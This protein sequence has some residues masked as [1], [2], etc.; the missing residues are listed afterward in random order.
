MDREA[1]RA[2][3]HG[4]TKSWTWL[5]DWAEH[6]CIASICP[7][8]N[9]VSLVPFLLLNDSHLD[10]WA[11][12]YHSPDEQY[13]EYFQL[14]AFT[15]LQ[16][17]FVYKFLCEHS[18]Q[19][20][21]LL[22]CVQLFATLGLQHTKLPCSSTT[23]G[24]CLNMAIESVMP[25]N[26]LMLCHPLLLLPSIFPSIRVFSSESVL[27]IRRPKYCSFSFSISPSSEYSG[28]ISFRMD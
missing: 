16:W 18:V 17:I 13:L 8:T 9:G 22:R 15:K 26:H 11:T 14:P 28:L 27:R 25:S 5:S 10:R 24:T 21:H 23:S 2:A 1:W 6:F 3:I 20:V 4:V 19:S 7:M 12:L